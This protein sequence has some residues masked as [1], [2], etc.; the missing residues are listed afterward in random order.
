MNTYIPKHFIKDTRLSKC[1]CYSTFNE[2]VGI[3]NSARGIIE[4]NRLA[5]ACNILIPRQ[6]NSS[7]NVCV[8]GRGR[9]YVIRFP[10]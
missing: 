7:A 4:G 3:T 10:A 2:V 5:T 9:A 1:D 8:C 6:N